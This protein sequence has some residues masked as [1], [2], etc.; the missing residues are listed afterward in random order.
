MEFACG[1]DA[2]NLP[3]GGG[4]GDV[5]VEAGARGVEEIGGGFDACF[6]ES[7]E[8]ARDCSFGIGVGFAVDAIDQGGITR[9]EVGGSRYSSFENSGCVLFGVGGAVA[10]AAGATI[11]V[12]ISGERL[13]D[14]GGAD[15]FALGVSEGAAV[16]LIGEGGLGDGKHGE[17][18]D[19]GEEEPEGEGGADGFGDFADGIHGWL[20]GLEWGL[21]LNRPEMCL[22]ALLTSGFPT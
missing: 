8:V 1:S 2:L 4:W 22:V 14:E 16:G 3:S 6:L 21:V 5:G 11:E 10:G 19:D 7:G 12:A 15:D 13:A 9:G 20:D 17:G 18:V